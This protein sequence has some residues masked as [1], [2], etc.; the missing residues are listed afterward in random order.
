VLP[1][2]R[3]ASPSVK[4][5]CSPDVYPAWLVLEIGLIDIIEI[6]AMALVILACLAL[7]WIVG[8]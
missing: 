3:V 2:R 8:A 4:W 7:A 6:I 5:R 1:A